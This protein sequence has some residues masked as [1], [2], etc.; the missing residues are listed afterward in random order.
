MKNRQITFLGAGNIA[1]ALAVHLARQGQAIKLY[2]IEPDVEKQIN[3]EHCN[4]KYL[5]GIKLP[6][7]ISASSDLAASLKDARLVLVAVP[8]KAVLQ[9][10]K[11]A[12]PFLH[13]KTTVAFI[14]K[15]LDPVSLQPIA[16]AAQ[17]LLPKGLRS[18]VCILGGPA[19]GA[20]VVKGTPMAFIVAGKDKASRQ[21]VAKLLTGGNVK[22]AQS[23]DLMGVGLAAALKNAYAIALGFCDGL[24]YPTNAKAFVVTMCVSEMAGMMYKAGAHP[25]TAPSLAG[26]GDLL[27]T[28]LSPHGRNR[29]YGERLVRANTN[30]PK[31]LGLTT[32]EGIAAADLGVKLAKR[33]KAKA[34]LLSAIQK[35]IHRAAGFHLPFVDYINNLKL[36]LI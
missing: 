18:R 23:D 11:Q 7:A 9:V 20:E 3:L 15:G 13:A 25:K 17:K 21:D 1:T 14:S 2:C 24:Q 10:I 36:D 31:R 35:G 33:L 19:I 28:G 27:V 8:S 34:P 12:R 5:A 32:V 6:V 29:K 30:D 22:A 26:L 16:I 4:D